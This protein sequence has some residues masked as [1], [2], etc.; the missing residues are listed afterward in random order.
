MKEYIAETGG[1]YTYSDDI[2]NLQELALSMTSIFD[3]C[4][5]FIIS[6]CEIAG[7]E[8]SP[9]YVWLNGK[10][11]SFS[12]CKDVS[13]PYYIFEKNNIDTVTYANEINKK[14]RCN[15]LCIGG[16]SVPEQPDP[17]TKQ[18]PQYIEITPSYSPRFIDRF[19]GKYAVL[20]DSPYAKQTVKKDIVFAGQII[21]EK[22]IETKTGISVFN[23]ANGYSLKSIVKSDGNASVGAYLNGLLINEIVINANGSFSFFKQ[24]KEIATI[25]DSGIKYPHATSTTAQIGSIL[26]YGAHIINSEDNTDDGAV[27]INITGLKQGGTK[28]RNFNVYDGKNSSIP[29]FQVNGRTSAVLV[30][31]LLSVK[32]TGKGVDLINSDF[33]KT[34]TLLTNLITWKDSASEVLGFIGYN[35]QNTFDFTI[36][37]N[38]G[39]IIIHPKQ[40]LNVVG[41][42]AINGTSIG[43]IYVTQTD[44]T[45]E[46]KKKVSAVS[47]KQLST[48]DFTTEY[49]KKLDSISQG[50]VGNTGEGFVTAKDV[51]EALAKKLTIGS[52]LSDL[53]DKKVARTNLDIYS[54][55]ESNELFLKKASNLLEL[56]TLT[57][58][59]VNGLTTEQ[60]AAKKE[61]KQA[62][63]RNNIDAERKG[64]ADSKLTKISN[65]SDLP[66]KAQ[67]RKNISVY[68]TQ[69]IDKLLE[70]KL[71][72]GAEYTGSVFTSEHKAKLEAIKTGNFVGVNSEGKSVAQVEG[73]I[74]TSAIV[75]EMEKKANLLMDGY[76]DSQK[77]TIATN[78]G[79]YTKTGADG[80]FATIDSLFQDYITHLVKQGKTTQDAQKTL[81]DKINAPSKEDVSETYLRKDG[82]LSDLSLPNADAKKAACRTLGAAYADDYQTK[83]LDTGWLQMSNS[84]SGTDTRNLF[85]RQIGNI[86]CIQG[87]INT[88]KKDGSNNGGAV[89]IIP[90][91]IPPPKYGVYTMACNWNDDHKYNRG[92]TF[93]IQANSRKIIIQES[94]Y[95]NADTEISFTYMT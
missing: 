48:E 86:V 22:E 8:I 21:G 18:V 41:D 60:I 14:G 25:N 84:G 82:K 91:Q 32:N 73:Y 4:S 90:N 58:D 3:A 81:R 53:A 57:A 55:S 72:N 36:K 54:K 70:G 93:K 94:G 42:L 77:N 20:L 5:N 33:T 27:N 46:L 52:N 65:L 63:V 74:M 69:E 40:S 37:N 92:A 35:T 11:R 62:T 45:A 17:V 2:L 71:S 49:K 30:N 61:Q 64:A 6:G 78:L 43:S 80:K 23:A 75:R 85:I 76:N 31:G 88:A 59:E 13:Y 10:V 95:Y 19:I 7:S 44:F 89:A 66:D 29:L 51:T 16:I 9:G 50:S 1:R 47:G 28:Y 68:S 56:V 67:A 87:I 12:G 79:I 83:L 34:N 39:N 15:Y 38:L 24:N 26:I